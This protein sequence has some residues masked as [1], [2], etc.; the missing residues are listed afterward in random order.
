MRSRWLF[1]LLAVLV[2]V[3]CSGGDRW[4]HRKLLSDVGMPL[5]TGHPG[6]GIN[7]T[8][9]GDVY[10]SLQNPAQPYRNDTNLAELAG[11]PGGFAEGINE[12]G[13]VAWR[14]GGQVY[15][16]G[17][18]YA[19]R[20]NAVAAIG[21]ISEAGEPIWA[22]FPKG[23]QP[24]LY[25]GRRRLDLDS[26]LGAGSRNLGFF[27][28]NGA[29]DYI[30]MGHGPLTGQSDHAFKNETDYTSLVLG[31]NGYGRA[32]W[33]NNRGQFLWTGSN[34]VTGVSHM[35]IDDKELPYDVGTGQGFGP[36][37]KFLND[38]GDVFWEGI[39]PDTRYFAD[40]FLNGTNISGPLFPGPNFHEARAYYLSESGHVQWIGH[41][42][43]AAG[44]VADIYV[45]SRNLSAEVLGLSD[46][47]RIVAGYGIDEAGHALWQG[48]GLGNGFLDKVYVDTFD[49][50]AD[51]LG[52]EYVPAY[53]L[54]MGPSG[55]VLW[56]TYHKDRD[57]WD[58]WF[59]SPVP[60]P[61]LV[62]PLTCLVLLGAGVR[63]KVR[64][65]RR[66]C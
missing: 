18:L 41:R 6:V 61:S 23:A 53:A 1:T 22:A 52:D 17:T 39:G 46:A 24:E 8:K 2:A 65:E 33:I 16:D 38:R 40:V 58:V 21:G 15:V 32:N 36:L 11:V 35:Y 25:V 45:D 28:I 57:T 66:I 34:F 42:D 43:T 14:Y 62:F 9:R 48:Y 50:S 47:P 37:G 26:I 27:Q 64:G 20:D 4:T 59:S 19:H 55:H 31:Q 5:P 56:T 10:Y 29:G 12:S 44:G 54:R 7:I 63:R 49:L 51:A 13:Q 30:W 60:E 3:V